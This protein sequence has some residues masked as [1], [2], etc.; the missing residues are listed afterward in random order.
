M[1][2]CED[3]DRFLLL[4]PDL[5]FNYFQTDFFQSCQS[6]RIFLSPYGEGAAHYLECDNQTNPK[7]LLPN[8]RIIM[9]RL[10][11]IIFYPFMVVSLNNRYVPIERLLKNVQF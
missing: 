11:T 6:I 1:V 7:S 8:G 9:Y 5:A 4:L 10:Q 3:A 2:R